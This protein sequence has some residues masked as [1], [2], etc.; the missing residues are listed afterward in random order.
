MPD[1][2]RNFRTVTA[3]ESQAS[4]AALNSS[5]RPPKTDAPG[6][7]RED[8]LSL[9]DAVSV[10]LGIVIGV[11]IFTTPS[12]VFMFS[13]S[14]AMGL[15]LW[16]AGGV[17]SVCGALVYAEL[18]AAYPRSGGEYNYLTAAYGPWAGFLFG[19]AQLS[20]IQT[21]SIGALAYV[22]A[23][24]ATVVFQTPAAATAVWALAAVLA[25]TIANALGLA[26]G[27]RTQNLLTAV[28]LIG[29]AGLLFAG[30]R[31]T[32]SVWE[33]LPDGAVAIGASATLDGPTPA[34][35]LQ[36]GLAMVF[37]LYAY[38][39][40]ND[41]GF[42]VAEVRD[43]Q[44]TVPRALLIGLGIVT[45]VYL[46]LNVAYLRGL[47]FARL[48]QTMAPAAD[49]LGEVLGRDAGRLMALL[50]MLSCLGA[51]NGL[52]M[53]VSRVH[54]AVGADHPLF[55]SLAGWSR[56]HRAPVL[57][58]VT[59]AAVTSVLIGLLGTAT[60]RSLID[61]VAVNCGLSALP[62]ERYSGGFNL[63]VAVSAPVF[64]G[65]FL[66]TA[67]AYFVLRVTAPQLPRPFRCPG[68]PVV[69]LIFVVTC[70]YMLHAAIDYAGQLSLLGVAPLVVG[71]ALYPLSQS[72]RRA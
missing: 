46:L 35:S 8:R 41:A 3:P 64:W 31:G 43:P 59:Q 25:C 5:Q 67:V 61:L 49:C 72:L 55:A 50:V 54:A 26:Y 22:F 30:I 27:R 24:N 62:W 23:E 21:G 48:T 44:R 1:R 14:P 51:V 57:A 60:G 13:G 36:L 4:A 38:G 42:I 68:F 56:G 33:I 69:P 7:E 15:G 71:A 17:V 6:D 58:L 9:W 32:H 52:I 47:G 10:I 70:G 19:W 53:V 45:T 20:I 40:W 2:C 18:A 11:S 37:V 29:L 65:S 63:L 39:G 16:L 34:V 12:L 66:A 28:K